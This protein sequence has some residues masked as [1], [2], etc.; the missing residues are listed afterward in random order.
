MSKGGEMIEDG[1]ARAEI[2]KKIG[3]T[4]DD[5]VRERMTGLVEEP[6]ITSRV[7]QR[8][9]DR[10]DGKRLGGYRVRV[11]T[12]TITSHGRGSLEKP[13][14][15]D[16]YLAF[17]VEDARGN[18]TSKGVLVQAKRAQG[19]DW[20]DLGEQCRR[21]NLVTK[22]GSVVWLYQ[23]NGIDV[24]R[25]QDVDKRTSTSID[26]T[27]FFDRVLEC[28]IGDRRKVPEGDFVDRVKLKAMLQDLGAKN[29]VWLGLK[30][31]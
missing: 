17:S 7:G 6:D 9:E 4:L 1:Q 20:S 10:F 31:G 22:K 29:A 23:P 8:L 30:R 16:L 14:G 5:L 18:R 13:L 28:R 26:S 27:T 3:R 19:C 12:E 11:I 15:T 24:I 2:A 25:S 21:M